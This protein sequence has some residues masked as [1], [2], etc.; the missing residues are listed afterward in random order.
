MEM[1]NIPRNHTLEEDCGSRSVKGQ[2]PVPNRLYI[3]RCA[4]FVCQK[5][6]NCNALILCEK[7]LEYTENIIVCIVLILM[8][9]FICMTTA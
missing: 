9:I 3:V 7:K 8:Y 2:T 1:F 5:T 6:N 4:H